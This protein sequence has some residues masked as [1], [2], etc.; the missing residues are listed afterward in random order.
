MADTFGLGFVGA[1]FIARESHA[2]SLQYVPDAHVAGIMNPTI[3]KA[4]GLAQTCREEDC[5]DPT[6]YGAVEDLVADPDVDGVYVASPN[7]TRVE[8]VERIVEELE[9]GDAELHGIALEK[10]LARTLA[11]AREIRDL[12]AEAGLAQGYLENWGYFPG[13]E[14]VRDLLWREAVTASGVPHLARA[15]GEH[16]GGHSAWFWEVDKMGGGAI[17]DM[18]SHTHLAT[19]HL[20]RNPTGDEAPLTPVEVT[21]NTFNLKW[22]H[23]LYADHLREEFGVEFGENPADDYANAVV[24]FER[25]GG[26]PAV[27]ESVASWSYVGAGV[28]RTL[29]LLGPESTARVE[30]GEATTNIFISDNVGGG[31]DDLMEKQAAQRG[32]M[33]V[34]PLDV[35]NGGYVNQ[36]QDI[37]AS[38]RSGENARFDLDDGVQTMELCMASYKSAEEGVTVDVQSVDLE[39]YVPAPVRREFGT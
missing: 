7:Y 15:F 12:V 10:P 30:S 11:E 29:E 36:T 21:G 1:G 26:Q 3:E 9:Q 24:V 13:V 34:E 33:P 28:H 37:V 8:A 14:R 5:G 31:S 4:E 22:G 19:K 27:A 17:M 23:G 2:M 18:M 32:R 6:A 16:S 38:F 39:D 25:A 20:L 35:V